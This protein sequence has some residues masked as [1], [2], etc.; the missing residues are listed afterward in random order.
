MVMELITKVEV[1]KLMEVRKK[2]PY[3]HAVDQLQ[4]GEAL[5]IS[6]REFRLKYDT[7]V[8]DYFLGRFNRQGKTISCLKHGEYYYIVK[9]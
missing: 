8:P 9:L 4:P 7:P 3:G 6:P 5:K 1:E 2:G